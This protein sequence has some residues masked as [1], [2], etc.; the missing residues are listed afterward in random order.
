MG[1]NSRCPPRGVRA[2]DCARRRR[3]SG[4]P[5]ASSRVHAAYS[6]SAGRLPFRRPSPIASRLARIPSRLF[7]TGEG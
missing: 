1:M 6:T 7:V 4:H 2:P 3:G 5:A